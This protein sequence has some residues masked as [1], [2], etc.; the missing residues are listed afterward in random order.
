LR[1]S[2]DSLSFPFSRGLHACLLLRSP[3]CRTPGLALVASP[4]HAA[5]SGHVH[6]TMLVRVSLQ[7]IPVHM[8]APPPKALAVLL[9]ANSSG[10]MKELPLWM[11]KSLKQ[12]AS[13][14]ECIQTQMPKAYSN[15]S[16][17]KMQA[18]A[19][20]VPLGQRHAYFYDL[21]AEVSLLDKT[22]QGIEVMNTLGA[23]FAERWKD[24][25]DR[26]HNTGKTIVFLPYAL[27]FQSS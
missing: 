10:E 7:R 8:T 11:A 23:A 15:R 19:T 4:R 13:T 2:P 17:Q 24:I 22:Q 26:F 1:F 18:G 25:F 12:D 3:C 16:L 27:L 6:L 14:S 21:G 20:S 5:C 9:D